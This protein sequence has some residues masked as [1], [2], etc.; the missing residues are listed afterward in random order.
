MFK[1]FNEN[2]IAVQQ[3]NY[4][5]EKQKIWAYWHRM[6]YIPGVQINPK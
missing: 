4:I 2:N 6:F 1:T 3:L 5:N